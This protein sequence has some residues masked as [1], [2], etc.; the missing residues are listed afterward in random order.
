MKTAEK[1]QV[2]AQTWLFVEYASV[3]RRE[4]LFQDPFCMRWLRYMEA[5]GILRLTD[6]GVGLGVA[7]LTAKGESIL[8]A[9]PTEQLWAKHVVPIIVETGEITL[10]A[11]SG[12]KPHKVAWVYFLGFLKWAGP[13]AG[14]I[15]LILKLRSCASGSGTES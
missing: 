2:A 14:I 1:E 12:R 7:G 11:I 4:M 13:L 9:Y 10:E 15:T 6:A 8:T 3:G 5:Q